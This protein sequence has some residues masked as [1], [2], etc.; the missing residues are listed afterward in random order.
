M[1]TPTHPLAVVAD[2]LAKQADALTAQNVALVGVLRST[3][4]GRAALAGELAPLGI[5][6]AAFERLLNGQL[7]PNDLAALFAPLG[8]NA[9]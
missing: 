7:Q 2:T 6:P 9:N 8:G 5:S 4:A 3:P 1:S